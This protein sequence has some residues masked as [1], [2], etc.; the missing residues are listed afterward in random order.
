M[1]N[2]PAPPEPDRGAEPHRLIALDK[3]V[4]APRSTR[5]FRASA[6]QVYV[7]VASV[8]FV[9]L[10]FAAHSVPYFSMDLAIT[11]AL[12]SNQALAFDRLM[13]GVSW[14]G[15]FPQM[16]PLSGSLIL[17][18]ALA[19]LRWEAVS[20]MFATISTAVA[21]LI[22]L[23][24][25]RPRPSPDI[26]H[27][28]RELQSLSF[29]SG[30]VLSATAFCGF[31]LFLCFTLLKPSAARTALLIAFSL[32]IALM[33][34]SRIYLGQHWFSDVMGAYLLGSLWLLLTIRFYR[35]GKTRY[36]V[37]QPLAPGAAA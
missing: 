21:G 4:I 8:V 5:S 15:F 34:P 2:A 13:F 19:G 37:D 12:Q 32:I 7:M 14:L 6:F 20:L 25:V 16:V 30:H 36:F 1:L 11:R 27:V 10:A 23:I 17:A 3:A 26:V 18:V 28:Y 24:V 35:W 9:V 33:G 29:P 22:K 31:F